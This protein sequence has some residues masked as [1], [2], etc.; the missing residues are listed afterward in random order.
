MPKEILIGTRVKILEIGPKDAFRKWG[1]EGQ[2]GITFSN[3]EPFGE[4]LSGGI[5]FPNALE[6][7]LRAR[8]P[9][10]LQVKVRNLGGRRKKN[11]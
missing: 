3:L 9:Y 10:F 4:W 2:I 8:T 5:R 6:K 11:G 7:G 1:L